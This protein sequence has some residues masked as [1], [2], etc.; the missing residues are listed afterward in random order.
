MCNQSQ[1]YAYNKFLTL[2]LHKKPDD[3]VNLMWQYT[4]ST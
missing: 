1:N 3:V 4:K 2:I